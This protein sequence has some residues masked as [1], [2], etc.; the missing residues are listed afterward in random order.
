[1]FVKSHDIEKDIIPKY[2]RIIC[3]LFRFKFSI[4]DLKDIKKIINMIGIKLK[5]M[6]FKILINEF[7]FFVKEIILKYMFT[8]V[9]DRICKG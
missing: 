1:M 5:L 8:E 3:W 6:N 9:I 2:K 4:S 7:L